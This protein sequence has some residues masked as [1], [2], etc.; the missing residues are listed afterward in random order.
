MLKRTMTYTDYN[1]NE[2]TEDF[3]FNLS[4]GELAEM[5]LS[6]AG[7]LEQR[8]TNIINAK[9]Q[10]VI[11]EEFKAIIHKAYGRKS[12]D[13]KYF[14]KNEEDLKLFMSTEAY[15]DLFIELATN[16]EAAVAFVKGIM[17]KE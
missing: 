12:D 14:I 17:P 10:R 7:G 11:V 6:T 16:D 4:K 13:G 1:G 8:L 9:D 15:S 2:R 3:Y 5:E